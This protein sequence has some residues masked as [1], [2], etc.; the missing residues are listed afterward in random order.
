M[1]TIP[2]STFLTPKPFPPTTSHHIVAPQDLVNTLHCPRVGGNGEIDSP[3][4]FDGLL[5]VAI[6]PSAAQV[7]AR[8]LSTALQTQHLGEID[9]PLLFAGPLDVAMNP[10][11]TS[12]TL[13]PQSPR[14]TVM[15][16]AEL[17]NTAQIGRN[18]NTAGSDRFPDDEVMSSTIP[19]CHT[20][21][22][23]DSIE[24]PELVDEEPLF[25]EILLSRARSP[26]PAPSPL[27]RVGMDRLSPQV[28]GRAVVEFPLQT[29][30][31]GL[32]TDTPYLHDT[33]RRA[34]FDPSFS[35]HPLEPGTA[36]HLWDPAA[37]PDV[38]GLSILFLESRTTVNVVPSKRNGGVVRVGDVLRAF[39]IALAGSG[40]RNGKRAGVIVKGYY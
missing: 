27:P 11:I 29:N 37:G 14:Q 3:L 7:V 33:V 20:R 24:L 19:P 4:S 28:E 13:D 12:P 30:A 17:P 35:L 39:K 6:N 1:F 15:H 8:D 5:D 21:P 16:S 32:Y 31:L 26:A 38:R 40:A 25:Q 2:L 23:Y 22:L 36:R 18:F 34:L 10:T 9:G